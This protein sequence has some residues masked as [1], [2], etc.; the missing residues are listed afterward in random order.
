VSHIDYDEIKLLKIFLSLH[1]LCDIL[2]ASS[3]THLISI[4]N[5]LR[6]ALHLGGTKSHESTKARN[7]VLGL[8]F[9]LYL[10][11]LDPPSPALSVSISRSS[12][13]H[14]SPLSCFLLPLA[15]LAVIPVFLIAVPIFSS[16]AIPSSP[17]IPSSPPLMVLISHPLRASSIACSTA[18]HVTER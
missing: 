10:E 14:F 12:L 5:W 6:S 2:C 15:Y 17:V 1:I 11:Y 7:R 9:R 8:V 13:A 16:S 18:V 3:H 4:N